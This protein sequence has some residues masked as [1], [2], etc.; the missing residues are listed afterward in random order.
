MDTFKPFRALM[1]IRERAHLVCAP[2]YDVL[3]ESEALTL[4]TTNPLTYALI[5]KSEVDYTQSGLSNSERHRAARARIDSLILDGILVQE[6]QACFYIYSQE[7]NG[8]IQYGIV[9]VISVEEYRSGRIRKHELTRLEKE[10]ERSE[11]IKIVGAHTGPVFIVY[12]ENPEIKGIIAKI[13]AG[14]ALIDFTA[15]D[16]FR[17][18]VWRVEGEAT[19][20]SLVDIFSRVKSFYIADGH[21]RAAAAARVAEDRGDYRNDESGYFL[22]VLFPDAQ[23]KIVAYNRLVRDL[24]G[25][26]RT[27]FLERLSANFVI[28][29]NFEE[30]SPPKKGELGMYLPE[31]W[32]LL[33][34][35][36]PFPDTLV[37]ALDVSILQDFI[38]API[39]GITEP[40]TDKR[41]EFIGGTRGITGIEEAVARGEFAVGFSL[42]PTSL[43]E[44]I[45]IADAGM[46]MPPK[47]TWFEPKLLSGLFTHLIT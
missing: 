40:R 25:L 9:G 45:A 5:E 24:G 27:D 38:L 23:V 14:R 17:H 2:P 11:H 18:S 6:E 13:S 21:H 44:L 31:G 33:Q 28:K 20:R 41:I 16:G 10:A 7:G 34:C 4:A 32:Y 19:T 8:H 30:K 3:S 46:L 35:K 39:L 15:S 1:P 37:E 26:S 47:S 42:Y 29:S 22:S 12:P 43:S 36:F